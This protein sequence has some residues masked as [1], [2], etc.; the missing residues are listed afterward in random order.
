M[1]WWWVAQHNRVTPSPSEFWLLTL[2]WIVTIIIKSTVASGLSNNE[3]QTL[4]WC[5]YKIWK[6]KVNSSCH[7]S[8]P[9]VSSS[10]WKYLDLNHILL[11]YSK[12]FKRYVFWKKNVQSC[13]QKS[14]SIQDKE[15]TFLHFWE[16]KKL[17]RSSGIVQ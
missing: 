12:F 9:T 2:T 5:W 7:L 6:I 17:S 1:W 14:F 10:S 13:N 15:W 11:R 8:T 3:T 4:C 16:T